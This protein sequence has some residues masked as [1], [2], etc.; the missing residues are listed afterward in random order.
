METSDHFLQ[1][2]FELKTM[3]CK[4]CNHIGKAEDYDTADF[5]KACLYDSKQSKSSGTKSML[6]QPTLLA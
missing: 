4:K 3:T 6:R 2:D 5:L 1:A